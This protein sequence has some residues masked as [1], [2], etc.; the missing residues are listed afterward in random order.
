MVESDLRVEYI[1]ILAQA[2][3]LV[4]VGAIERVV[5]FVGNLASVKPDA[6]DK[7]DTDEA[8][9]EYADIVQ[10]PPGVVRSN[11]EANQLRQER[12]QQ[13][14]QAEAAAMSQSAAQSAKLLSETDTSTENGLTD[15]MNQLGL[16]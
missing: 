15:V 6:V 2:Q 3:R 8:I 9:D 1:S 16:G 11:D 4:G 13:A 7:I 10:A 5:S 12:A 14:A